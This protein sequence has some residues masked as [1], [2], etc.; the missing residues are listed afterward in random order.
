MR[1]QALLFLTFVLLA[2]LQVSWL[3]LTNPTLTFNL[4]WTLLLLLMPFVRPPLL[5]SAAI[6]MAL[7]LDYLSALPFGSYLMSTGATLALLTL[8]ARRIPVRQHRLFRLL[9]IGLGS[10]L[11]FGLL[12]SVSTALA[13]VGLAPFA[14]ALDSRIFSEWAIFL[15]WNLLLSGGAFIIVLLIRRLAAP[16]FFLRHETP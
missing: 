6:G 3:N 7:T 5:A 13:V 12:V 4:P 10:L 11:M 9:T 15:G 2:H 14:F 8:S 1:K 16:H